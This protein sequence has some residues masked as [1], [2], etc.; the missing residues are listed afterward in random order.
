MIGCIFNLLTLPIRL[1]FGGRGG[2]PMGGMLKLGLILVIVVVLLRSCTGIHPASQSS[3]VRRSVST[4][5]RSLVVTTPPSFGKPH[6]Y[7][8]ESNVAPLRIST[9]SG[10]NYFVVLKDSKT[11]VTKVDVFLQGGQDAEFM[12][13]A[14][15]Y[16]IEYSAGIT[17]YGKEDLFGP[18][19][20]TA[21]AAGV[22]TF[23]NGVGVSFSLRR[24]R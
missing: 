18:E 22:A 7:T 19:T 20:Q 12:V 23:K 3:A 10:C 16:E 15:E 24:T 13:P 11:K 2:S 9:Q 8:S 14:G 21:K 4:D 17:W 6:Y 5:G 1:I